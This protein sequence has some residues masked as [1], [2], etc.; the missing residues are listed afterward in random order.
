[1]ADPIDEIFNGT[2]DGIDE[3]ELLEI[4]AAQQQ[5]QT[6]IESMQETLSEEQQPSSPTTTES[7][8]KQQTKPS[9]EEK[10]KESKESEGPNRLQG[11]LESVSVGPVGLSDFAV[12]A[13]NLIP[14]VDIP[15]LPKF[16][17]DIAQ[18]TREMVSIIGPTIGL[19]ML[20]QS[21]AAAGVAL[22]LIH[23]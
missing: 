1:M 18:T 5:R 12:D 10:P 20:G 9:T 15:K 23:I 4:N 3:E 2:P 11:A 7:Q 13:I 8:P 22:S 19:T 14:G 21:G 17:N 16:N 6:E